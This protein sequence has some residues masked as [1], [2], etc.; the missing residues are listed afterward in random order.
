MCS[1]RLIR[2][3]LGRVTRRRSGRALLYIADMRARR[4][5][6]PLLTMLALALPA[7]PAH[8]QGA[9]DDQY[10]DPFGANG[11]NGSSGSSS[12]SSAAAPRREV[13]QTQT[14]PGLSQAP[15]ASAPSTAAP[16]STPA[17]PAAAAP[18]AGALPR[19]GMEIPGVALLGVGLLAS[20]VG[21]R[22][23]TLDDTLY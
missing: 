8:A 16:G 2:A 21:L 10:Q 19:T 12:K 20:G 14:Q 18:A 4:R 17:A 5:L 1:G 13:A 9:G 3:T 22:L 7:V 23:R 15:P 11:S 6:A